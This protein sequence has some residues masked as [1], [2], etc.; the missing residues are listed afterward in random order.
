MRKQLDTIVANIEFAID[1][2]ETPNI[3]KLLN[4]LGIEEELQST[5][6]SFANKVSKAYTKEKRN[7][8]NKKSETENN[9]QKK[10]PFLSAVC[11]GTAA[12]LIYKSCAD[13]FGFEYNSNAAGVIT[14]VA[15]LSVY[16]ISDMLPSA[17]TYGE[18]KEILYIK[19]LNKLG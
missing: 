8:K 4:S 9:L 5:Y 17:K 15:P 12:L 11:F 6:I 18:R 1:K 2:E 16:A 3:E 14:I 19:T 7:S 13:H 10:D